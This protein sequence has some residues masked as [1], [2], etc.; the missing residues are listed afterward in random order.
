MNLLVDDV[1]AGLQ[2]G[3]AVPNTFP[4][5]FH[6]FPTLAR[7]GGTSLQEIGIQDYFLDRHTRHLHPREKFDPNED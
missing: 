4:L 2:L 6:Q 3:Y 1:E 5:L 7:S